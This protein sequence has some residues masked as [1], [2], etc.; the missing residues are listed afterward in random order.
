MFNFKRG[1]CPGMDL[2]SV[3]YRPTWDE[4]TRAVSEAMVA[5]GPLPLTLKTG[6]SFRLNAGDALTVARWQKL[7]EG[8][9]SEAIKSAG[10]VLKNNWVWKGAVNG[11]LIAPGMMLCLVQKP[12][13]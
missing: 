10:L 7:S 1:Q 6:D 13:R 12:Q 4:Q 2:T 11:T 8:E 3:V 9:L 5:D